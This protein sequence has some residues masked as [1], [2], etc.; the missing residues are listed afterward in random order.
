MPKHSVNVHDKS[1]RPT[2]DPPRSTQVHPASSIVVIIPIIKKNRD[3]VTWLCGFVA[4]SPLF[5]TTTRHGVH[6]NHSVQ[7]NGLVLNIIP[8]PSFMGRKRIRLGPPHPPTHRG[9]LGRTPDRRLGCCQRRVSHRHPHSHHRLG[10]PSFRL[11]P[12]LLSLLSLFSLLLLSLSTG[13]ASR[14]ALT[15]PPP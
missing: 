6:R 7:G 12:S 15:P 11:S 4:T 14:L 10:R 8:H 13:I 1:P 5:C 3:D 2:Q 9:L